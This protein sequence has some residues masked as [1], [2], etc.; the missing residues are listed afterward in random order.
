MPPKMQRGGREL[1]GRGEPVA[2]ALV[3]LT[4]GWEIGTRYLSALAPAP[5]RALVKLFAI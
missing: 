3:E 5:C 2:E 1:Q 4:L